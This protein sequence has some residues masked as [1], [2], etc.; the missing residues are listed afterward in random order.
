MAK[1]VDQ[2][3]NI[4]GADRLMGFCF[5][6]GNVYVPQI[7]D[8]AHI[9]GFTDRFYF[10]NFDGYQETVFAVASDPDVY[11]RVCPLAY[12]F[13]EFVRLILACGSAVTA[14]GAGIRSQEKFRTLLNEEK[15]KAHQ[16]L[17]KLGLRFGLTPVQDPFSYVQTARQVIDC[18]GIH[19]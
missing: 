1:F 10:C 11:P 17:M 14:A 7:P 18:S 3:R 16:G 9:I 6:R 15:G 12:D 19:C 4:H 13:R 8:G 5:T 2:I